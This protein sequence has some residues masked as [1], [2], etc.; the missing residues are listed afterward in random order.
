M[1]L[2]TIAIQTAALTRLRGDSTLAALLGNPA[3]PP[4]KIFDDGGVPTLTAYPLVIVWPLLT[5]K[6]TTFA[7]GSD[8]ND[9][10]IQVSVWSQSGETGGMASARAIAS[11]IH[12]LLDGKGLD[13]SA[14]GFNNF[15]L[16]FD[17]E[18]ADGEQDDGLTQ[19][20]D[21]RYKLMTQ[22]VG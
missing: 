3:T 4:G 10:Y 12:E 1:A 2:P 21:H 18:Q 16:L 22:T 15:F 5:E 14:S 7:M 13:L 20:I 17:N 6:G 19:K 9:T 8:A 11:Q